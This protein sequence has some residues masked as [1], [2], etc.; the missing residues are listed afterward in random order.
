[1]HLLAIEPERRSMKQVRRQMIAKVEA[2][3]DKLVEAGFIREVN[4]GLH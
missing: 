3:V 1:M 2:E 4:L